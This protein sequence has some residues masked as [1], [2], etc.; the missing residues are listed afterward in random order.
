MDEESV[1][2]LIARLE[3]AVQGIK[4]INLDQD[5]VDVIEDVVTRLEW[6]A[7]PRSR[8]LTAGLK[9]ATIPTSR[10]PKR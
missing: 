1:N 9:S 6:I 5:R 8:N 4:G 7:D 2:N 3:A 10:R